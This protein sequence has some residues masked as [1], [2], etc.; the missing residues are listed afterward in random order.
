MRGEYVVRSGF[1][2]VLMLLLL[3]A[4]RQQQHHTE[5]EG[6]TSRCLEPRMALLF[7]VTT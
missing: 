2:V 5:E 4:D 1:S 7:F 3:E 6:R